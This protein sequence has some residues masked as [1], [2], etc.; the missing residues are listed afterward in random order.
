MSKAVPV[1]APV[2]FQPRAVT[3]LPLS[4]LVPLAGLYGIAN[5]IVD[6]RRIDRMVANWNEH[7]CGVLVVFQ[8]AVGK[9]YH[10]ISGHHR[11]TGMNR[12]ATNLGILPNNR[13]VQTQVYTPADARAEG[14]SPSNFVLKLVED[15]NTQKGVKLLDTLQN[16]HINSPW[17]ALA[18]KLGLNITFKTDRKT[19]ITWSGTL[20]S[21]VAVQKARAVVSGPDAPAPS[22]VASGF[23]SFAKPDEVIDAFLNPDIPTMNLVMN[24]VADW[25]RFAA[26]PLA[27]PKKGTGIQPVYLRSAKCLAFVMFV[28]LEKDNQK[29]HAKELRELTHRFTN[30]TKTYVPP[31]SE[32]GKEMPAPATINHMLAWANK[33]RGKDKHLSILGLYKFGV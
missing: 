28:H 13:L 12:V 15:C 32:G 6:P 2:V 20:Q 17:V 25:E 14:I 3:M 24:A 1:P 29:L 27:N 8:E 33:N 7:A 9:P 5:R 18:L 4:S 16:S 31:S 21:Y 22:T 30:S 26:E 11:W 23:R 19:E 10:I